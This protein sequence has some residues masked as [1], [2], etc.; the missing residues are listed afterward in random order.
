MG[1]R[2][3]II[4]GLAIE[5]QLRTAKQNNCARTLSARYSSYSASWSESVA[6]CA[7][8][9]APASFSSTFSLESWALMSGA[10]AQG[11][12]RN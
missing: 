11:E 12:E 8:A 3:R 10:V 9:S 2:V 5:R 7:E 1:C 4:M 6:E